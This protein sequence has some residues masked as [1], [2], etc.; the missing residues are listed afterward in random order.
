MHTTG[1]RKPTKRAC[2]HARRFLPVWLAIGLW[3]TGTLAS[4][5]QPAPE[6]EAKEEEAPRV[7][8]VRIEKRDNLILV[9]G[10]PTALFWAVGRVGL[11]ELESYEEAGLNALYVPIGA[12]SD[13]ALARTDDLIAQAQRQDLLVVIGLRMPRS[14]AGV[15]MTPLDPVYRRQV[16]D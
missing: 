4:A 8:P 6:P 2:A 13:E 5:Q 1:P 3:L 10:R 11:D 7:T 12:T 9:D 15:P 16:Q 14:E